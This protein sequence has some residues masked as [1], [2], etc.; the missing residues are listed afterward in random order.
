M[1]QL[2]RLLT[3]AGEIRRTTRGHA[4]QLAALTIV[5]TRERTGTGSGARSILHWWNAAR[6]APQRVQRK[7]LNPHVARDG[8]PPMQIDDRG[9]A[10]G[11]APGFSAGGKLAG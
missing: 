3:E 2:Q 9:S 5:R 11:Q 6:P 7:R 8:R 1:E 10:A 4:C